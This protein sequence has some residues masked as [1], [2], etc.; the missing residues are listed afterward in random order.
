ME[1]VRSIGTYLFEQVARF[2]FLPLLVPIGYDIKL[3][4]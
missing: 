1:I 2:A 3:M 4:L